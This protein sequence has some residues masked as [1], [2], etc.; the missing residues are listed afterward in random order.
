MGRFGMGIGAFRTSRGEYGATVQLFTAIGREPRRALWAADSVPMAGS[1]AASVRVFL[2]HNRNG[3]MDGTD[4][5]IS[6]AGFAINGSSHMARTDADGIAYLARLVPNQYLDIAVDQG[7]LEDPQWLA[8]Q[9]GMRIVPRPGKV[10]ELDFAIAITGEIDGTTY[11]LAKGVK[12][13][14][15]DVELE[16]VDA[17]GQVA[18]RATSSADGYYILPGVVPGKY[19]L[20]VSPAQL[21]RLGMAPAAQHVATHEVTM[22][23]DGAFVNGKDLVIARVRE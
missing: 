12:R 22:R 9:K 1:G 2:D 7:T 13:P 21:A 8:Q 17:S 3:I 11:M 18:I 6:G 15:G 14:I 4:E 19:R 5:A 10:S 23:E 20:R 16:L